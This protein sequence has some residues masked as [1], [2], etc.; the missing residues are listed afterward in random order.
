MEF[1]EVVAFLETHHRGVI[2][3]KTQSG[4]VHVS[5]VF[6]GPY[7]GSAA[8]VSVYP[9]SQKI[10]NLRLDNHCSVLAVTD[11]WKSFV[12]IEGRATLYDYVNTAPQKMQSLLREVY[13]ACSTTQHPNW[14]DFDAAMIKQKAVVVLV[15]PKMIYG[16]IR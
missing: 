12:S 1:K 3:T 11:D 13:M 7:F 4:S 2:S 15:R 14:E 9:R 10:K 8:F 16:S 6:C 5:I